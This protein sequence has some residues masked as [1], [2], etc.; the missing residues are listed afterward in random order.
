MLE[1][2]GMPDSTEITVHTR[3]R[4]RNRILGVVALVLSA[5][6]LLFS[7]LAF[8]EG[9]TYG[10][11]PR[12][13]AQTLQLPAVAFSQASYTVAEVR[14]NGIITLTLDR[15]AQLTATVRYA[16]SNGTAMAGSDYVAAS[17]RLTFTPGITRQTFLL[18]LIDDFVDEPDES[19][20]LTLNQAIS[21]TITGTNPVTLTIIDDEP[22]DPFIRASDYEVIPGQTIQ[23]HVGQHAPA[24]NPYQLRWV[25]ASDAA[26]AII[27]DT[28]QVDGAG[29][30]M[31]VPYTVP[32]ATLG[33]FHVDTQAVTGTVAR[34][35]DIVLIPS[36]NAH[37][38]IVLQ[39]YASDYQCPTTSDTV[40]TQGIAWQ[41][42]R[43][44]PVRPAYNHAG[45]NIELPGYIPNTDTNFY[46][47]LVDY[48]SDDPN[49]PPQF[50]TFFNPFRVSD[51]NTF[52]RVYEWLYDPPPDPGTRGDPIDDYPIT[53]LGLA[54]TPGEVLHVPVSAYDIGGGMEVLVL[55]ADEDTVALR[56]TR[57]DSSGAPGYTLHIDN[58]CTDPNLL[59]L[60]NT[61]DDPNGPRYVYVERQPG[62][63]LTYS[64]DL[65]NLP[66]G[67]P[68]GTAR[69]TE[70]VL[71][72]VDTGAFQDPRS[73]NEWWQIKP[74]YTGTCPPHE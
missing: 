58:I 14:Q 45:K 43:D 18:S 55:F 70:F 38:P 2:I 4:A 31:G 33:T 8:G 15:A 53:A 64:Y 35:P 10:L 23:V 20:L 17:G 59:A 48:G 50:A 57:E 65:P 51:L 62:D 30:A 5:F 34:S 72:I 44:D 28:L 29:Y 6:L 46:R 68:I 42:D 32:T 21:A 67:Y 12:S 52:Y 1:V 26:V 54:T 49:Q 36:R 47:E 7:L 13:Q 25:D 39:G 69:S 3:T 22:S 41:F 11:N 73:C 37:L 66:A 24:L 74:G 71:A 9:Q 56:Y 60:Y 61:L 16:T 19:A 27:S 40:Y 63:P